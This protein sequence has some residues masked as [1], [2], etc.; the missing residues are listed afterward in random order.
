M[1]WIISCANLQDVPLTFEEAVANISDMNLLKQTT[2]VLD[3]PKFMPS[4]IKEALESYKELPSY[5]NCLQIFR[6]LIANYDE[7]VQKASTSYLEDRGN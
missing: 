6:Q 7:R 4:H 2:P 1:V 3:D 5:K